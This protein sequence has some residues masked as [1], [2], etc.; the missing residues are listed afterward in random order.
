MDPVSHALT[1]A[2]LGAAI[3]TRPE[4]RRAAVLVG[5][6]AGLLPDA[7]VFIRSVHDPLLQLEYHRGFT[8]ALASAPLLAVLVA[9][10][11]HP[12][13]RRH[14]RF[15]HS[16][17]VSLLSLIAHGL[18]DAATSYGT[19]LLWPFSDQRIGWGWI[20]VIDPLYTLPA[21][22]LVG[23]A[24]WKPRR[25]LAIAA[26]GWMVSY[27]VLG[28]AQNRRA[29]AAIAA[30][31]AERGHQAVAISAKPSLLN[32]FLFRTL[33]TAGDQY[34]VDA[35]RVGY[36]SPAI[37]YAG[38]AV[39]PLCVATAFPALP[40]DSV[41]ARDIGRFS[42]F[43]MGY[44]YQPPGMPS[45][46]ADLRY[47]MIPNDIQPLWGILIDVE[48]ADEHAP[49]STFRVAD[50]ATRQRFMALLRGVSE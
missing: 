21:L 31:A 25:W 24:V 9:G 7:D 11:L 50:R 29:V 10:L 27:L 39:S 15:G 19:S 36:F 3:T 47:A 23:C 1:G 26:C 28:V 49:F 41:L 43:S 13:V 35:V 30:A 5:A 20:A 37:V 38:H 45:V 8:H 22:V 12:L 17:A 4:A 16:Y 34:Y 33:Y 6:L 42:R 18:L 44:L 32:N 46:V 48:R 14:L 40:G 2:A